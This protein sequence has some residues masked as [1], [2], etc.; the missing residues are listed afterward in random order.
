MA[1]KNQIVLELQAKTTKLEAALKRVQKDFKKTDKQADKMRITTAGLR[2]S[3]GALRNNML[4]VSFA[5]GGT[6]A[7]I[8]KLISAYGQQELAEKKLSAALG[9]TSKALLTQ[10]SAL[11]QTTAFGDEAIIGV[12]ALIGAFTKDE[13]QIKELTKTT[14]DLAAAKGMDLTAAADLVSKSF[15]SSTNALSRYGIQVEGAVGS[16][17]RLENLTGNV[18]AL[19]GGQAS[20]QADT[21]TGS[22]SQMKNA[23][24][25]TAEA[26]GGLLEPATI[27][28]SKSIKKA[29][30]GWSEFFLELKETEMETALRQLRQLGVES[31]KLKKL[32]D[33]VK[34]QN[35]TEEIQGTLELTSNLIQGMQQHYLTFSAVLSDSQLDQMGFLKTV[36]KHGR[37]IVDAYDLQFVTSEKISKV[38]D[39]QILKASDLTDGNTTLTSE[40]QKQVDKLDA[41]RKLIIKIFE[42]TVKREQIEQNISDI[43][44][45]TPPPV[46]PPDPG[47]TGD[48]FKDFEE[49]QKIQDKKLEKYQQEQDM[50]AILVEQNPLLAASLGLVTD[51]QKRANE[52]KE[53][54]DKIAK[55]EAEKAEEIRKKQEAIVDTQEEFADMMTKK[56]DSY[57]LEQE[58]LAEWIGNNEKLAESLGIVTDEQKKQKDLS[59]ALTK[60]RKKEGM[61]FLQ[62]L[63]SATK[64]QKEFSGIFKAA[65]ITET[66]INTAQAVMAAYKAMAGIPVVGPAL[67]AAAGTAAGLAGAAQIKEITAAQYGM[68]EV[69]DQPTMILAGEA[70]AEQVSITPLEGP[71]IDGVQGGGAS[72][73]VNVSGNVLTSDFVEGELADNIREA[74]RRGTDFGIG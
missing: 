65:A 58:L 11:Q 13:E 54:A 70:G 73:V 42:A 20:A 21:M 6:A 12:Q 60:T 33:A 17:E 57:N 52:E 48:L 16:T 22:I 50:I 74:V 38:L 43:R 71:N 18:A 29:A 44:N 53:K 36:D 56:H 55:K 14:L 61:Q 24:G 45:N 59:E 46:D 7:S 23:V 9:F 19:F 26:M 5:L 35:F 1:D 66:T 62:N 8:G 4:L 37:S 27:A 34:M 68:N 39:Q 30:E 15:G 2:R 31:E 51:E 3:I 47:D 67:G 28:F 63:Q 10:A 25:D 32:T 64:G 40:E 69:V 72:V 41:Q 49:F